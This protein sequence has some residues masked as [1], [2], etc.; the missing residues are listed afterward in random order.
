MNVFGEPV[1]S[2]TS[3]V[4]WST[5]EGDR[6]IRAL[7]GRRLWPSVPN[8][9]LLTPEEHYMLMKV[10]GPALRA[11][12]TTRIADIQAL[13]HGE[14]VQVVLSVSRAVTAESKKQLGLDTVLGVRR[15]LRRATDR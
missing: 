13:P 3:K 9:P 2:P 8:D 10:R 1:S 7:A 14:A 11:A 12:L 4:F 15:K 6:L 5:M